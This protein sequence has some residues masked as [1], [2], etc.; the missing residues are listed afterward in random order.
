MGDNGRSYAAGSKEFVIRA[1]LFA[2]LGWLDGK[3]GTGLLSTSEASHDSRCVDQG[4]A[5]AV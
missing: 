3:G 4:A 1:D 5:A 2:Q